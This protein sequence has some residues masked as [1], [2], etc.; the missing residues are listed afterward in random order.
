M[1]GNDCKRCVCYR[2]DMSA[3][4]TVGEDHDFTS[5]STNAN[6]LYTDSMKAI[7]NSDLY[8]V[9]P[10]LQD[11]KDEYRLAMVQAHSAALYFYVG[12]E[13]YK[14]VNVKD[15]NSEFDRADNCLKSCNEHVNRAD[16]LLKAIIPNIN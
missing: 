15:G 9:S 12:A 6:I 5:V 3:I 4:A 14:K 16:N 8:T 1:D 11:A 7:E 13:D 10:D 2:D